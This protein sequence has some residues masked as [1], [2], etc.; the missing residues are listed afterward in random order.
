MFVCLSVCLFGGGEAL[1]SILSDTSVAT[2]TV[3][4]SLCQVY[5]FPSVSFHPFCAVCFRFVFYKQHVGF[6][7]FLSPVFV[8][9]EN[10]VYICLI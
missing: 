6:V 7:F 5:L 1:N 8:S 3:L 4:V 9:L 2:P 10:L